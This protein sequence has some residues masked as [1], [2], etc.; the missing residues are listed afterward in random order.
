MDHVT[1]L[2]MPIFQMVQTRNLDNSIVTK[3]ARVQIG[4]TRW[5]PHR[6]DVVD[7]AGDVDIIA[8]GI[9]ARASLSVQ[10]SHSKG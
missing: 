3:R 1:W 6:V 8:K 9:H 5:I 4:F 7:M 2:D 10:S